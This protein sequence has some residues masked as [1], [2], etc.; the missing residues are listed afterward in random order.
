ML[1]R[2][3]RS[4]RTDTLFPYTTLFRSPLFDGV[5]PREKRCR[6]FC[7]TQ[8]RYGAKDFDRARESRG[9]AMH[10][11]DSAIDELNLIVADGDS[12]ALGIGAKP[13]EV[14]DFVGPSKP[15]F[16]SDSL[17]RFGIEARIVRP[18][19]FER[20]KPDV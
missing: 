14:I 17:P 7:Q 10:E 19:R 6:F 3:P 11:H 16:P 8:L 15:D 4:T 2:P 20:R 13:C 12:E 18:K 1:R 9:C 5:H